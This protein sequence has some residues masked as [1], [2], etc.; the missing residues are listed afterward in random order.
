M[1]C[2]GGLRLEARGWRS[3]GEM[4]EFSEEVRPKTLG[5]GPNQAVDFD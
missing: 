5:A 3:R 2:S 4:L 1:D